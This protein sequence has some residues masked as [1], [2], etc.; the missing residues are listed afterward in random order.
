M[1]RGARSADREAGVATVLVL[2]LALVLAAIAVAVTAVGAVLVT[3]Q[4]AATAAD[5]AALAVAGRGLDGEPV[6]CEAGRRIAEAHGA[7]LR[8]CDVADDL[9]A[10]VRVA[11]LPPGRL[12]A[13]GEVVVE[14][15]AGHR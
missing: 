8:A 2:G 11:V 5:L 15:R 1:T 4:R 12:G 3:R 13:L 9:D 7:R 10:T 14:A 6:A